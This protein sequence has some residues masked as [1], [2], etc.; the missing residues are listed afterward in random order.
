LLGEDQT[1]E[2]TRTRRP[3]DCFKDMGIDPV[4]RL[5]VLA[6]PPRRIKFR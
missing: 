3:W 1:F 4:H 5:R 2:K 6:R